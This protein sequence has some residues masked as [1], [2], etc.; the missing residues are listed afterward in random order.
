MYLKDTYSD[1]V[2]IILFLS[3]LAEQILFEAG[4]SCYQ[5]MTP[6][7]SKSVLG[8]VSFTFSGLVWT[9]S[10]LDIDLAKEELGLG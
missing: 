10:I 1:P 2:F 3:W 6:D 5:A 9:R 7:G 4:L 8:I